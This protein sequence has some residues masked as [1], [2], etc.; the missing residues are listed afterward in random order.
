VPTVIHKPVFVFRFF[1]AQGFEQRFEI[2][3]SKRFFKTFKFLNG[4]Y[5]LI[6]IDGLEQ[7]VDSIDFKRL[8]HILIIGRRKNHKGCNPDLFKYFKSQVIFQMYVHK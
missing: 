6:V 5:Q 2:G 3:L 8:D 4:L 1:G 7:V